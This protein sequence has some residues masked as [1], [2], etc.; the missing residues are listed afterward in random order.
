MQDLSQFAD[1]Q[2]LVLAH[3]WRRRAMHGEKDARGVAHTLEVEIRRRVGNPCSS[4]ALLDTRPLE[5]RS[6]KPWWRF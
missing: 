4:H 2:L 6:R 1:D 5:D 3:E